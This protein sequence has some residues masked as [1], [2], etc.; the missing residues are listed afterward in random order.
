MEMVGKILALG[1]AG[2]LQV[3]V[4]LISM[5]L[6][7]N[8]ASSTFGGFFS[9]IQLPSGFLMLGI[10]YFV[11]GYTLF[12]VL[13]VGIGAISSNAQQGSQLAMIYVMLCFIPLWTASLLFNFPNISLWTVLTIFPITAPIQAMLRLG[14]ADIPLWEILTSIG[15][16]ALRAGL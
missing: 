1:L 16:L 4:W 9:T 15:V 6:L 3:L 13:S 5:P 12:A 8:L 11:L 14:V 2:L 7:L 10:V